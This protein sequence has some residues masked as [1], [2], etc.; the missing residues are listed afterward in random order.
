MNHSWSLRTGLP[1]ER[2]RPQRLGGLP[3]CLIVEDAALI[4]LSLEA[5][6]EDQ[7]YTCSTVCSSTEALKWLDANTPSIAILDYLLRDGPCTMVARVLR[8]RGVPFLIYSGFPT[9]AACS[10]LRGTTWI[11]KPADRHTLLHAVCKLTALQPM[12]RS[13]R[14]GQSDASAQ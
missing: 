12:A 6:L 14:L 1:S 10:E 2:L 11:T 4:S 3:F 7:G 8:A 13:V 9:Q 5:D